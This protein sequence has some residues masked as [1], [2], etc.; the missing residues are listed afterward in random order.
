MTKKELIEQ[1]SLSTDIVD[2]TKAGAERVLNLLT[3]I[4]VKEIQKG[5]EVNISGF[6][7]F[8]PAIQKGRKGKIPSNGKPYSTSDKKVI[9]F[10]A[11]KPLKRLIAGQ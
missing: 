9:K 7:K 8:V 2:G 4:I 3:D 1:L 6:G 10:R 5:N 11:S